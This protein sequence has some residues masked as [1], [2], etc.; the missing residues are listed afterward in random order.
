MSKQ[1]EKV[2]KSILK[3][4]PRINE[5]TTTELLYR[6]QE[7]S[8]KLD[9]DDRTKLWIKHELEGYPPQCY[10]D[11]RVHERMRIPIYRLIS[12]PARSWT[13]KE[14]SRENE[15]SHNFSIVFPC[16]SLET[17]KESITLS[18]SIVYDPGKPPF[19]LTYK[20]EISAHSLTG[21]S[22]AIRGRIHHFAIQL[23]HAIQ[24]GTALGGIFDNTLAR[25][26]DSIGVLAP[27]TFNILNEVV[28]DVKR[29]K[30]LEEL[31]VVLETLRT[32]IRRV[33][34]VLVTK[35][36]LGEDEDPPAEN[37]VATKTTKILDW[38]VRELEG[39]SKD[40]VK[41]LK[42]AGSRYHAQVKMILEQINKPI[43]LEIQSVT[44]AQVERI[45]V[46]V[47]TWI[48]NIVDILD[49]AGYVWEKR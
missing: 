49:K 35:D 20:G 26:A 31:R 40:E 33:T 2:L 12:L 11:K 15:L 16:H 7:L 27:P 6:C 3:D 17:A 13:S 48:G 29:S 10:G 4:I 32:A 45:L 36:M 14:G 1:A 28:Q 37:Q 39:S 5:V 8:W 24:I 18:E 30:N 9:L 22:S 42:E 43:H 46:S 47:I 34:S 21:I 19:I 44:K 25:I 23:T 41:H 38:V